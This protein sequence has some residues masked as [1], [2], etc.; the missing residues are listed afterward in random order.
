MKK[1]VEQDLMVVIGKMQEQ[2]A[3]LERKIDTLISRPQAPAQ[4]QQQQTNFSRPNQNNNNRPQRT[5]Y[6]IICA[7]CSKECEIPFKPVSGRPVYCKECFS[8]RRAGANIS[9]PA[10]VSNIIEKDFT[11]VKEEPAKAKK[12]KKKAIKKKKK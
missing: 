7:D 1:N 10:P 8:R 5:F 3:V 12:T 2:L 4:T 9:K 11:K 6:K